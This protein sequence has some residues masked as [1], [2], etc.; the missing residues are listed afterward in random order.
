MKFAALAALA[1]T[2][3]AKDFQMFNF[4]GV[5]K[6]KH[7]A[8]PIMGLP[9]VHKP[10]KHHKKTKEIRINKHRTNLALK[11]EQNRGFEDTWDCMQTWPSAVDGVVMHVHFEGDELVLNIEH[12]GE[13]WTGFSEEGVGYYWWKNQG[14]N[15]S[16]EMNQDQTM[17]ELSQFAPTIAESVHDF[18]TR[19]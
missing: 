18:C 2:A 6:P 13:D 8:K 14:S 11:W 10:K 5:E 7:H 19:R 16:L 15:I 4:K 17:M 12:V 9:V 1:A 3:A